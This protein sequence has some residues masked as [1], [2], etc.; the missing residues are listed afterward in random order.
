MNPTIQKLGILLSVI[1]IISCLSLWYIE[2]NKPEPMTKETQCMV[3]NKFSMNGETG[4]CPDDK[5]MAVY[6]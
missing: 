1:G 4:E 6:P 2:S 5:Q 3:W